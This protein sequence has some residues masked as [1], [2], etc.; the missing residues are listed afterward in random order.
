MVDV[1]SF[2]SSVNDPSM[3]RLS[4]R[5]NLER[6]TIGGHGVREHH[7]WFERVLSPL[8][9]GVTGVPSPRSS[10]AGLRELDL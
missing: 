9:M 4:S 1:F 5:L 7:Q 10:S 3:Q 6:G 8:G 2:R